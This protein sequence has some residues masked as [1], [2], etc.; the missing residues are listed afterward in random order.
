MTNKD[1]F[2]VALQQSAIDSGC[3]MDDFKSEVNKV[4]ISRESPEARRYLELP[5]MCD[6][7]SYGNNIVASVSPQLKEIVQNYIDKYPVEHCFETPNLHR[8]L[9]TTME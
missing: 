4:V 9:F 3:C 1:I 7:T 5:F 6:L 2:N 8:L